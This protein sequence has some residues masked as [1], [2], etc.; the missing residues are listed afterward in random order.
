[1]DTGRFNPRAREGRDT[2]DGDFENDKTRF[3]P[4]AREG[5]DAGLTTAFCK[6]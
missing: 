3:N 1:M 5:R 2:G 4:R 6:A